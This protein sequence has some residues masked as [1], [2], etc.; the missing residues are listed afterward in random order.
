M[1]KLFLILLVLSFSIPIFGQ[2]Y[3]DGTTISRGK[4]FTT[5]AEVIEGQYM[6][7]SK[8]SIE[9]YLKNSKDRNVLNL[10]QVTEVQEYNGHFG[11]TGIWIGGLGGCA[12]GVVVALGTK[13]TERT[14]FGSGYIEET[15][16]QIWPIYVFSAAGALIGYVIGSASEDWDTV[17][18][19]EMSALLKNMYV[20]QNKFGGM[21]LS[22]TVQF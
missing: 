9:Y 21:S 19:N 15:K 3:Q 4:I 7:F 12:I 13:E 2:Q 18:S 20:K 5:D 10:N 8:D 6:V 22:Y 11:N 1:R 14:N 17:Y 16:I